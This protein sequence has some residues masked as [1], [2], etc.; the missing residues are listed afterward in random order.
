MNDI[1]NQ[2]A[3]AIARR[4]RRIA[5]QQREKTPEPIAKTGGPR[6]K[7]SDEE[8]SSTTDFNNPILVTER[9]IRSKPKMT[10]VAC[11]SN[12]GYRNKILNRRDKASGISPTARSQSTPR[13]ANHQAND[14][15]SIEDRGNSSS[16]S[17]VLSFLR[18]AK[19]SLSI[20]RY[21]KESI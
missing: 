20:P 16:G 10:S 18:Q 5:R 2:D 6:P 3:P 15:S 19:R 9:L 4:R 17:N 1:L 11:G 13:P 21:K 8:S 12:T 7:Y 14:A